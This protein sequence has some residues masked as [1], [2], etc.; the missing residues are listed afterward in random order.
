[1][2]C[3]PDTLTSPWDRMIAAG[4]TYNS[5]GENIAAGYA[6][7]AAVMVGWMNS[8]G[9]R[10]NILSAN[11]REIGV[12]YYLDAGDAANVRQDENGDCTPESANNGPYQRY[13]TQNF[14]RRDDIMPVVIAR[15]AWQVNQCDIDLY[16]YGAGWATQYR[17]SNDGVNWSAWQ[18][19]A[20]NVIWNLA[21]AAGTTATVHAQIRSASQ[22]VRSAQDSVRL[23]L[24]CAL[25]DLIFANG[26]QIPPP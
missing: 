2:H 1:M 11:Y 21:G 7:P 6:T 5:A 14:G 18:P 16:L 23:G 8:S 10:A 22:Q 17:L 15:E 12:G 9:H 3:D 4:Y 19:Y 13:W 25:D 26:F 24:A 20:A